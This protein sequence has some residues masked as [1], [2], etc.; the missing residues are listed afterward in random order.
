MTSLLHPKF[1]EVSGKVFQVWNA[2]NAARCRRQY[3]KRRPE[4]VDENTDNHEHFWCFP[5]TT[6]EGVQR[7]YML[8]EVVRLAW[9]DVLGRQ[10][11]KKRFR[12][13]VLHEYQFDDTDEES[14]GEELGILTTLRLWSVDPKTAESF[15][16][17]YRPESASAG[18]VLLTQFPEE[19]FHSVKQ[20]LAMINRGAKD[21]HYRRAMA[22]ERRRHAI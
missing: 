8:A 21:P 4:T 7:N 15:D 12:L 16:A 18:T 13:F 10:F 17:C 2:A 11:P 20:V 9:S 6:V 19:G 1:I 5:G 3:S 22:A 14:V